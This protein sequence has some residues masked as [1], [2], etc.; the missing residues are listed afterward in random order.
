MAEKAGAALAGPENDAIDPKRKFDAGSPWHCS[1]LP[2][3][4][5]P[6]FVDIWRTA[7][8]ES[9]IARYSTMR[10]FRKR[11]K[12]AARKFA[13]LPVVRSL[14]LIKTVRAAWSPSTTVVRGQKDK[15]SSL[16]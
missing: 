6:L 10:L 4:A 12:C 8:K 14:T 5:N 7:S 13:V 1:Q 3:P 9:I 2:L 11:R 16:L 15:T